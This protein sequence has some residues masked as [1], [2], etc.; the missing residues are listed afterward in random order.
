MLFTTFFLQL[1]G[2]KYNVNCAA[3]T[4][5]PA[6]RFRQDKIKHV[7]EKTGEHDFSQHFACYREKGNAM[8][9][10]TFCSVTPLLVY[11][12][13]VGIFPLLWETFSGPA[14]KDEIV[15][16]SVKAHPPYLMTSAGML[17][18]PTVL[19]SLR[20]RMAFS[21]SSKDGG[22]SSFVMVGSVGRSSRKPGSVVWTL[23]SRFCSYSA[24]LLRINSLF[25]IKTPSVLLTGCKEK[26]LGL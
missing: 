6:L 11:R 8:T 19:L 18:G 2:N 9:V 20:Q 21:T 12:N 26:R 23:F 14:V 5:E 15:Q 10:A 25:L 16:P 4:P 22:S 17:S 7:L 3:S 1:L 13:N 24:H